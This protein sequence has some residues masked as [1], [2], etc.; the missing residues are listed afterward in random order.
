MYESLLN[1]LV[2]NSWDRDNTDL[3]NDNFA[4]GHLDMGALP[5]VYLAHKW[6]PTNVSGL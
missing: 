3:Q 1:K 2:G 6:W 5:E 4:E